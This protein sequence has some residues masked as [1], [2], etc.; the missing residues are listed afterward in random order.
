MGAC[1]ITAWLLMKDNKYLQC[2]QLHLFASIEAAEK[3]NCPLGREDCDAEHLI[4]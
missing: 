3:P 2:L 1:V 4:F